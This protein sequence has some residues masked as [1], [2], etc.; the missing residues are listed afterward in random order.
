QASSSFGVEAELAALKAETQGPNPAALPHADGAAATGGGTAAA[1]DNH[2][3]VDA[4]DAIEV[5]GNGA[6]GAGG[7]G[8]GGD[9]S[10]SPAS[11]KPSETATAGEATAP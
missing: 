4:V 11:G 7:V 6:G 9:G 1:A 3:A 2:D 8:G 5:D 10:E